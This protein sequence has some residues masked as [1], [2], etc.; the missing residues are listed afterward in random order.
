MRRLFLGI[1]SVLA[2]SSL[3]FGVAAAQ[4]TDC[5]IVN[6]GPNSNNSCTVT[7]NNDIKVTCKNE[8]DVVFVNNQSA[9]SGSVTLENNTNGGFAYSGNAVNT[10]TTTG[11]LDVSCGPKVASSPTP[12]PTPVPTPSPQPAAAG[13]QGAAASQPQPQ[14]QSVAAAPK[15]LPN[16]GSA[17]PVAPAAMAITGLGIIA[18]IARFGVAA[19]RHFSLK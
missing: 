2:S 8:A 7:N 11:K 5:S 4:S 16:T 19:Y 15:A 17:S 13:G 9:N 18:A 1:V 12:A 14:S 10:N 6:T 3:M